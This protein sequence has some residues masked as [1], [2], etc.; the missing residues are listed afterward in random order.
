MTEIGGTRT[1]LFITGAPERNRS[2]TCVIIPYARVFAVRQSTSLPSAKSQRHRFTRR[3]ACSFDI[4]EP[5]PVVYR[6]TGAP[7]RSRLS[8]CATT[9][10]ARVFAV[11]QSPSLP[12]AKSQRHRFTRRRACSSDIGEPNPVVYRTTGAPERNRLPIY[13]TTLNARVFAVRQSPLRIL[14]DHNALA[15]SAAAVSIP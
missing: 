11:R 9:L 13:A 14:L 12:F 1:P 3:R 6:T 7:E 5:N 4:G 10:N 2:S 8:I 15:F